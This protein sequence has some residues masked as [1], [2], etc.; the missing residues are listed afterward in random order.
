MKILRLI[1]LQLSAIQ[2]ISKQK[3]LTEEIFQTHTPIFVGLILIKTELCYFTSP[4]YEDLENDQMI[5]NKKI[6]KNSKTK[7]SSQ[8]TDKYD[9][10]FQTKQK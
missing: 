7:N 2:L 6:S 1:L 8:C 9:N 3:N 10:N 5:S 4:R